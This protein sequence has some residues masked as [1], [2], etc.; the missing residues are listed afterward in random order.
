M[1]I[2]EIKNEEQFERLIENPGQPFIAT[3]VFYHSDL[4]NYFHYFLILFDIYLFQ[5][6]QYF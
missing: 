5:I 4:C 1:P 6:N 3:F 2:E